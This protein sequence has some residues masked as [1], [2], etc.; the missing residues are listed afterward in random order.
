MASTLTLMVGLKRDKELSGKISIDGVLARNFAEEMKG[1]KTGLS[2][3][4]GCV[5]CRN[6]FCVPMTRNIGT[7][8]G[9]LEG[10]R[11]PT[12]TVCSK[13]V[14]SSV[15]GTSDTSPETQGYRLKVII[16]NIHNLLH[17]HDRHS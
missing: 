3:N 14:S 15:F 8:V 2:R 16:K 11:R 9:Y 5:R 1:R 10:N 6:G 7:G 4:W 12:V 17:N 13:W